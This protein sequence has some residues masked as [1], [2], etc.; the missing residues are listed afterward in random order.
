MSKENPVLQCSACGHQNEPERV[1]CH[2]CGQKLDRSLLPTP[3]ETNVEAQLEQRRRVKKMMTVRSGLFGKNVRTFISVMF[4]AALIAAVYLVFQ[5]PEGVPP[6][7]GGEIPARSFN[8]VWEAMMTNRQALNT[9]ISEDEVNYFLKNTLKPTESGVPGIKFERAFV[10]IGASTIKVSV[11][12]STWGGLS[13]FTT[14][15]YAPRNESGSVK[16]EPVG[17]YIGRLGL[18]PKIPGVAGL[19]L[20]GVQKALEKEMGQLS[21]L[22]SVTPR[23]VK[24]EMDGKPIRRGEAVVVTKPA[25]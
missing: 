2:N 24:G 22:A 12:R 23:E 25:P 21:R 8:E 11:E 5:R 7:K 18:H 19:G 10:T 16:F 9:A 4:F 6:A 14:T 17:I 15:E 13:I 20:G 1:Y 3:K